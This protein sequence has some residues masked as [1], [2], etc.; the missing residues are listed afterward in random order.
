MTEAV[1]LYFFAIS[2]I[3]WQFYLLKTPTDYVFSYLF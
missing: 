1:A 3:K 2:F